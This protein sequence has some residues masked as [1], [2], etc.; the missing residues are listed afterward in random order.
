MHI[1]KPQ[2]SQGALI[3]L[4]PLLIYSTNAIDREEIHNSFSLIRSIDKHI[5]GNPSF[6][7]ILIPGDQ[8]IHPTGKLTA[9]IRL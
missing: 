6:L 2:K 1:N 9:I 4:R 3:T 7:S 5:S 8:Q